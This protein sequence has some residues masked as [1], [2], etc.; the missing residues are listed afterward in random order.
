MGINTKKS[1]IGNGRK[2]IY[3]HTK[4]SQ[5]TVPEKTTGIFEQYIE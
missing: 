2:Y 3:Y 4:H 5:G 1:G